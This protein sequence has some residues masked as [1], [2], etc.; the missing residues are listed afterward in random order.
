MKNEP[1]IA[2]AFKLLL[3]EKLKEI[4]K[5]GLCC[6]LLGGL[7]LVLIAALAGC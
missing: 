3:R 6:V 5:R 4:K 7:V 1:R 2:S